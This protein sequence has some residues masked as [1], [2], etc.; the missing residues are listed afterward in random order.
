MS[1]KAII[2]SANLLLQTTLN[3]NIGFTEI[4]TNKEKFIFTYKEEEILR[5]EARL[6]LLKKQIRGSRYTLQRKRCLDI[7]E[8]SE[9]DGE[10]EETSLE[11]RNK[12]KKSEFAALNTKNRVK[13]KAAENAEIGRVIMDS[14]FSEGDKTSHESCL[15]EMI[16]QR[17][18]LVSE[19]LKS[20]QELLSVQYE[21]ANLKQAVIVRHREN[22]ILM[23]K[24]NELTSKP[25]TKFYEKS[26][27]S[28]SEII[29]Q[30]RRNLTNARAKRE[31]ARN[32]LQGLI[33][34]SGV[35]WA[36]DEDLLKLMLAIGEE[37]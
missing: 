13:D 33:L 36:D 23:R 14:L 15:N 7:F 32:I 19:F 17:D 30:L 4:S 21:L 28:Q 12:E 6:E 22:R 24:I 31:I 3:T 27:S 29:L 2:E 5:L 16:N 37:L 1:L 10:S 25:M 34:E 35:E 11:E 9:L 18:L 8:S 20:H 26:E